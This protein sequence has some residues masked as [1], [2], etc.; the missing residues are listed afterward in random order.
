MHMTTYQSWQTLL[1]FLVIAIAIVALVIQL[2]RR[3]RWRAEQVAA[4]ETAD[5]TGDGQKPVRH[6]HL[7]PKPAPQPIYDWEKQGI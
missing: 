7:V 2:E 5:T 4:G 6:L 1:V 3:R